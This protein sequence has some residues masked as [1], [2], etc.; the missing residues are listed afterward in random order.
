MI[1]ETVAVNCMKR[2]D[3]VELPRSLLRCPTGVNLDNRR[4]SLGTL[5]IAH[6]SEVCPLADATVQS[7][8]FIGLSARPARFERVD[9]ANCQFLDIHLGEAQ[10]EDCEAASSEFDGITLTSA[11]K[12]GITGLRPGGNV[13]RVHHDPDGDLY[14]P[15]EIHETLSRLGA[16][17]KPDTATTPRLSQHAQELVT[18]LQQLPKAFR[19]TTHPY[20]ADDRRSQPILS[21]PLWP[22]LRDLL[23]E[24]GVLE[25]E[26]REA[27]GANVPA[28]RLR[29]N[30]DELLAGVRA[31]EDAQNS[32][33]S[34]WEA[35]RSL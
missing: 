20:E 32:T 6:T 33:A 12:I 4:R 15:E 13:R 9:F 16:D 34:L 26:I 14:A 11:S 31:P 28:Y 10:F 27:K 17:L 25:R 19:R 30:I 24:H 29:A 18:L 5:L 21:S 22:E 2:T 35:L 8:S 7:L 3:N 23:L 1:S